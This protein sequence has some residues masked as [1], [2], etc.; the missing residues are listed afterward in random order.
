MGTMQFFYDYECP[1]CKTGYEYLMQQIGNYPNIEIEW[2]PIELNPSP[3]NSYP[4]TN[5]ACQ[6]YYIAEELGADINAFHSAMYQAIAVERQN[7]EKPEILCGIVKG[8]V[9]PDKFRIILESGKYAKQ[10]DENND[11][12][13]EKSDVWYVPALRMNGKKLDA[14][15]GVGINPGALESFLKSLA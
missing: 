6:S 5:L 7:A 13:Y 12:A 11:L 2:R 14:K 4:C 3:E 9:D 15:G 1:H 8:I 10:V